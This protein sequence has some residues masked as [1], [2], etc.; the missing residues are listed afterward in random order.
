MGTSL[1]NFTVFDHQ[2]HIGMA[3]SGKAMGNQKG[4]APLKQAG[5]GVLNQ[6]LSLRIDG[7]R[8]LV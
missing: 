5:N 7:R 4:G 3:D 2:N 1:N 8:S 6:L